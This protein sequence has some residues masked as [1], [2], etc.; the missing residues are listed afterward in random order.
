M[1]RQP[2]RR[3]SIYEGA[4][5]WY[6]CYIT[7]GKKPSGQLDRR[8]LR[9]KT[10]AGV[11]EKIEAL[12]AKLRGG[13][14]PEVGASDT[15]A[16]WLEHW[17][18]TIAARK[19]RP[20]T[21][22]GYTSKIRH[23]LIPGIGKHRLDK[24][25]A[26]HVEAY[27]AKLES[28]V[29]PATAL[30]I[31]RILSRALKVANQRG[32]ISHNPCALVDAPSGGTAEIQPPTAEETRRILEAAGDN[33]RWWIA[34]GLGLRQGEALGL[35]WSDVDL[36]ADPPLI[37]VRRALSRRAGQGLVLAEPKSAAGRRIVPMPEAIARLM[38]A[39]H[40]AQRMARMAAPKWYDNDLVFCQAN[41]KP[42]DPRK[43]WGAWKA[44]LKEAGVRNY[45]LHDARHG[46]ATTWLATGVEPR[47]AMELLG[48]SQI[49]LTQRYTHVR[50]EY[51][52]AAAEKI[53]AALDQ[54]QPDRATTRRRKS[55]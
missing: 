7:V 35:R 24:L 48:H 34:L 6:H 18:T 46:A 44:L 45:R 22:A 33:P 39:H 43:D 5:G 12:N 36:E 27:Y 38:R 29:S 14:V 51:M 19:V 31:H 3:P 32:K 50:P 1:P 21:L 23:R 20:S 13:H 54:L 4:D 49:S 52:K 16:A 55:G 40:Q 47:V 2:N 11:A 30:Q 8:H 28:E 15:V 42:T 37:T 53:G 26:E 9:A 10:A 25:R 41:G 17:L